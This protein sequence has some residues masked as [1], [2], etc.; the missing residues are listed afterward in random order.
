ML[1]DLTEEDL[2]ITKDLGNSLLVSYLMIEDGNFVYMDYEHL[3]GVTVE[4]LHQLAIAN[5]AEYMEEKLTVEP[6]GDVFMLNVDG[7]FEASLILI[8]G[9]WELQLQKYITNGFTICCPAR[10]VLAFCDSNSENGKQQLKAI[11]DSVNRAD[12]FISNSLYDR[13]EGKWEEVI[14][15]Y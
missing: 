7:N 13:V 14:L 15:P 5:F 2:T 3:D 12:H 4:E 1:A 8:D 11:A 6:D 9:L 10:D